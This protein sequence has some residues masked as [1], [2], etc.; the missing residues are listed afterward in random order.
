MFG[1][2]CKIRALVS[3]KPVID[4]ASNNIVESGAI[5]LANSIAMVFSLSLYYVVGNSPAYERQSLHEKSWLTVL[6]TYTFTVRTRLEQRDRQFSN[7]PLV[8]PLHFQSSRKKSFPLPVN[9]W[10]SNRDQ[11]FVSVRVTER[12]LTVPLQPLSPPATFSNIEQSWH[13]VLDTNRIG[14]RREAL[15]RGLEFIMYVYSVVII[16]GEFR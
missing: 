11:I 7:K 10:E 1:R 15:I 5:N 12:K 9:F 4:L 8:R 14:R 16:L 13:R 3:S 6:C 2:A